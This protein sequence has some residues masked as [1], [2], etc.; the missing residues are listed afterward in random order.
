MRMTPVIIGLLLAGMSLPVVAQTIPAQ[1][2]PQTTQITLP[3]PLPEMYLG[4]ENGV[5]NYVKAAF[6]F[7]KANP[8]SPFVQRVSMDIYMTAVYLGNV[9]LAEQTRKYLL[10]NA[11]NQLYGSYLI[12]TFKTPQ[13]LHDFIEPYVSSDLPSLDKAYCNQLFYLLAA[14]IRMQ[15]WALGTQLYVGTQTTSGC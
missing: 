9:P 3:Y 2:T 8:K 5:Q 11:P 1:P 13:Q 14:A 4:K 10:L 6:E 12:S 7:I 15:G